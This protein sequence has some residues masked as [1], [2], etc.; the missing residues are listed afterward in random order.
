MARRS[1]DAHSRYPLCRLSED[2]VDVHTA[3]SRIPSRRLCRPARPEVH[4]GA[5]HPRN[6][7]RRGR[8]RGRCALLRVDVREDR[9]GGGGRRVDP[10]ERG[11]VRCGGVGPPGRADRGVACPL[12][13]GAEGAVSAK[14]GAHRHPR[15]GRLAGLRLSLL[16]EST[17][18]EPAVVSRFL[19]DPEGHRS[20]PR[21]PLRSDH[22]RLSGRLR[23]RQRQGAPLRDIARRPGRVSRNA[24]RI[25]RHRADPLRGAARQ[26]RA[27]GAGRDAS[28]PRPLGGQSAAAA[29]WRRPV[30][31]RPDLAARRGRVPVRIRATPH[32]IHLCGEQPADR[33]AAGGFA[34][35][36]AATPMPAPRR[37]PRRR[38]RGHI[39]RAQSA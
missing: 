21:R 1:Q 6:R 34:R 4:H 30:G 5:R 39:H 31:R 36:S 27:L 7:R 9:R 10:L 38:A 3:V 23:G 26:R 33:I 17:G 20:A 19:R 25:S 24:L 32:P 35:S 18:R 16:R 37:H 28:R 13:A 14:Q 2:G 29:A 22:R 12:G 11:D 8:P 15:P